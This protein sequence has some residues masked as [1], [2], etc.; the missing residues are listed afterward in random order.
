[1]CEGINGKQFS[2]KNGGLKMKRVEY[3]GNNR[4]DMPNVKN[5]KARRRK[6]NRSTIE[7]D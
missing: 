6:K 5:K 1:V 3:E 2:T 7:R 4:K